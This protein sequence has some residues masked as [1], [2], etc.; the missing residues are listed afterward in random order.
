MATKR[1][2][3]KVISRAKNSPGRPKKAPAPTITDAQIKAN[4]KR[5]ARGLLKA[6]M[7]VRRDPGGRKPIGNS[8]ALIPPLEPDFNQFE[9]RSPLSTTDFELEKRLRGLEATLG[10]DAPIRTLEEPSEKLYVLM[11]SSCLPDLRKLPRSKRAFLHAFAETLSITEASRRVGYHFSSHFYWMKADP[12]YAKCFET[13]KAIAIQSLEDEAVRRAKDGYLAPVVSAGKIV[14]FERKYSDQLMMKLLQ[15]F[16]PEAYKDRSSRE[17]TGTEG[18]P[19]DVNLQSD[20]G[21]AIAEHLEALRNAVR[22]G[23]VKAQQYEPPASTDQAPVVAAPRKE[24]L[25]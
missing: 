4:L 17:L 23:V 12:T 7:N 15:R 13:V 2:A 9:A 20:L 14:T 24:E 11:A 10:K 19:V 21:K 8:K 5:G 6:A 3:A 25:M 22:N 1:K 16:N 18:G